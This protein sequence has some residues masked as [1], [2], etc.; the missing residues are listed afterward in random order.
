MSP[1]PA[2]PNRRR[3]AV[4]FIL[5]T[6][7]A[8]CGR[9]GAPIPPARITERT[10]SLSAVQRGSSVVLSWPAPPM[11]QNESS[12]TYIARADVYRL[13]EARDE[14]PV[15][16]PE[17]YED[18]SELVGFLDRAA[19]ETQVKTLGHIEFSDRLNLASAADLSNVRLRYAIR[20]VN[21]RD[22]AGP[23]SNTV[24]VE[25]VA[26]VAKSPTAVTI[27]A[28]AQDI[29]QITWTAPASNVDDSEPAA[30]AGYNIY[31]LRA[32]SQRSG[33]P[34]N[35]SPVPDTAFLDRTF[36]YGVNYVYIVRALSQ[37]ATGL[38]ESADS[39]HV[40]F[41]AVDTF[42]P[43]A[44]EPVSIA[45]ANGVIS[46]FWPSSPEADVVGYNVYRAD[47]ADAADGSWI[48]LTPQPISPTTFRD[49]RVEI[50]RLYFYRVTAVDKFDNESARSST[51]SE[52]A[53]P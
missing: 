19:I 48:K 33:D 37:G 14:E 41:T 32:G 11:S 43:A 16:D 21:R 39:Q 17:D 30:V 40:E 3:S 5:V 51:V 13:R 18:S 44:P 25:P 50:D 1:S 2:S 9:V 7:L 52:T 45:S 46:L 34:I 15:L 49:E 22:Q 47:T 4:L 29:V 10:A 12:K 35:A 31:R 23:F 24:A 8:S 36:S 38:I 26:L 20:Y 53:H 28:A 6:G 42:P 27:A